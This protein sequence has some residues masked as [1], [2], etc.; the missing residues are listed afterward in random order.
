ME[1]RSECVHLAR[2]CFLSA[3]NYRRHPYSQ[4][5]ELVPHSRLLIGVSQNSRRR[6]Y[7]QDSVDLHHV[8][9]GNRLLFG[10]KRD[11]TK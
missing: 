10:E 8:Y 3:I 7:Y 6:A 5:A 9:T 2:Q 11:D 1:P 4:S